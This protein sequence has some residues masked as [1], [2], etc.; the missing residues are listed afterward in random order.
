MKNLK[1]ISLF[2]RLW[3]ML[4]SFKI[5]FLIALLPTAS[6]QAAGNIESSDILQD[7]SRNISGN[8]TDDNGEPIPGVAIMIKGTTRGTI[9]DFD[10][11]FNLA[12]NDGD[13]TLL[14]SFIGYLTQEVSIG[15][16][17]T[18]KVALKEATVGVEE[19]LVV[20]YGAQKK[21]SVVGAISQV[22]G[23]ALAQTGQTT[24]TNALAGQIP[25]LVSVQQ[26]GV[27]GG[28]ESKIYIRGMSSFGGDNTP[29]VLID[30]VERSM[31]N[32]D[33]NEVQSI[34]VL[35]DASATAVFGVKGANGVILVTTKRGQLGR[36]EISV[37]AEAT[38]VKPSL[39][40]DLEDSYNTWVGLNKV[41]RNRQEWG[42]V[43]GDDILAHYK[44]QDL[45]YIYPDVDPAEYMVDDFALDSRV[46]ISARGGTKT[47]KYFVS[48]GAVSENGVFK[49]GA[50][51]NQ[52]DPGY[53]YDRYNFRSN[54]DF[55]ITNTTEV[56]ISAGGF[57]GS[58]NKPGA[59]YQ[60]LPNYVLYNAPYDSPMVYPAEFV[61]QYP[62]ANWP[63]EGDRV[64]GSLIQP[65]EQTPYFIN[66]HSGVNATTKHRLNT[67][68]TLKQDLGFIT[69]GLSADALIS[70]NNEAQYANGTMKDAADY[71]I[72]NRIG[73]DDYEWIRYINKTQDQ[74]TIVRPAYNNGTRNGG[75]VGNGM[76][77]KNYMYQ[78]KMDYRRTFANAHNVTA[79]ALFKRRQ[80][81]TRAS[82]P[83]YEEDWVGRATYDY[84]NKYMVEF[85]AGYTGSEQFAP[86][87]RFGFF[88]AFA[89]GWNVAN[90][91]FM[92]QAAPWMNQFKIRYS[93]GESGNDNTGSNWLYLSEYTEDKNANTGDMTSS[94]SVNTIQEGKVPNLYAQWERSIKH[95]LGFEFGFLKDMFTLGVDLFAE[96]RDG[97]L[98]GRRAVGS[99]FGQEIQ[100]LN[101][102]AT[103]V[104][105]YEIELGWKK[106]YNEVN[107][108]AKGN[109]NFNE[110]R[111]T[112]RD[113]PILT[114]DYQKLAGMPIDQTRSSYNIGY[115]Q[116]MDDMINY[117]LANNNLQT[118]GT[119]MILDF[120][121]D[122]VI[123]SNDAVPHGYTSRPNYTFGLSSGMSYKNFDCNF[124]IQGNSHVSRTFGA[125]GTP[126]ANIDKQGILFNGRAEKVWTPE[127]RDAEYGAWG[128]WNMGQKA[129]IHAYYVR[130]KSIQFGYNVKGDFVNKIGLSSLRFYLQGNNL[131]TYAPEVTVGDPEAEPNADNSNYPVPKRFTLGLKVN[132]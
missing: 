53:S 65:G 121:G 93:Y 41:Y 6:L 16:T 48:L 116:N 55:K 101:I 11:N 85:N 63:Y 17:S 105:G 10:G 29:L 92:Q 54:F 132:F 90:E 21:E 130:L 125:W 13:A 30:G 122:G 38:L 34:S 56:S 4:L 109:F 83:H 100:P 95:N 124:L 32:I 68:F 79:L 70:Y 119:D 50:T 51:Q 7:N 74:E 31:D 19:V 104:H 35:K 114:P 64:G 5:C 87:N 39:K 25:G 45:P 127:Q 71:F 72:F 14:I 106:T 22:K 62:D 66:N 52:Y 78:I 1:Q 98:M 67:D 20:A 103:K 69:Q 49:E 73:E 128:A 15:A 57:I 102:G 120:N 76:P 97:I 96:E 61:A 42:K 123:N 82:F 88:P 117:K 81:Q 118:I 84:R 28:A 111:I 99:W 80:S 60:Y 46:N 108:W 3:K 86:E 27:P 33:P 91:S 24:V 113:D 94:G 110:N 23:E 89:L 107:V 44:N 37:Q 18:Y 36:M 8:V 43:L 112:E 115:Y 131:L 12:I 40:R 9:T 58:T 59:T 126:I 129:R 2:R 26:S 77:R 75:T 47:V